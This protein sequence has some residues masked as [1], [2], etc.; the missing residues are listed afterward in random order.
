MTN[1]EKEILKHIQ[2][3]PYITQQQLGDLLGIERSSVAVHI[4]N[5][6]NKGVIK[7]KGYIIEPKNKVVV[8][9]G[10]NMDILGTPFQ[11]LKLYDSNPGT[12]T[13]SPGGVG[14]NIAE[15]MARLGLATV[16]LSCVG[17]DLYGQKLIKATKSVGVDVH[18]VKHSIA[19]MTSTYISILE[20]DGDMK[21]ALSDMNTAAEIDIPYIIEHSELIK[22]ST[23]TI[24][25]TNLEQPVIDYLLKSFPTV[26]FLVD[27]V[28]SAK[29]KKIK[30]LFPHIFCIKPNLIE[31]SLLSEQDIRDNAD[32][33]KALLF[34]SNQGVKYPIITL[35]QKGVAYLNKDKLVIDKAAPVKVTNSNGAGDAF[36]AG[37]AYGF[38]NDWSIK[39]TIAAA[40]IMARCTLESQRTVSSKINESLFANLIKD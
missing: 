40:Q 21:I 22:N 20:K 14:R 32:I 16:L 26:R 6:I 12:V 15:N 11:S 27:T 7:G 3:N 38:L 36:T 2:D 28:S 9:G 33:H 13:T 5:L 17:D 34:F 29:A 8:I 24:V 25:D 10:S 18:Y 37:L 35:G 19:N 39:D 4:S 1:R 23:F 31:A 30:H